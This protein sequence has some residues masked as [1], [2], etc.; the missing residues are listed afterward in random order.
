MWISHEIWPSRSRSNS[1]AGCG[2]LAASGPCSVL[3]SLAGWR[4]EPQS[5]GREP[6]EALVTLPSSSLVRFAASP[7]PTGHMV[8]LSAGRSRARQCLGDSRRRRCRDQR[9]TGVRP[10][11]TSLPTPRIGRSRWRSLSPGLV[12][13]ICGGRDIGGGS[14]VLLGAGKSV[15][16]QKSPLFQPLAKLCQ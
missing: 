15:S 12:D 7:T 4:A 2:R 8:P 14:A 13:L 5:R 16:R 1:C 10:V 9:W 6:Q 11:D 3:E